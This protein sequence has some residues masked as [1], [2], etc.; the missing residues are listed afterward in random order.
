M[1]TVIERGLSLQLGKRLP[2]R[3]WLDTMLATKEGS[4]SLKDF[5]QYHFIHMSSGSLVLD[6]QATRSISPTLK[7]T[8]AIDI[9]TV[10]LYLDF[11]RKSEFLN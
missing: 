1:C 4:Q 6:T 10:E 9:A 8:G 7:S 11:W 5:F 2:F 3:E